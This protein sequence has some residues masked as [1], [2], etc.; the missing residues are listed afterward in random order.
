MDCAVLYVNG[1]TV[2]NLAK[3]STTGAG[4]ITVTDEM[5]T[6]VTGNAG[7]LIDSD[8]VTAASAIDGVMVG[9]ACWAYKIGALIY[10]KGASTYAKSP[11][12]ALAAFAS[13]VYDANLKFAY[14][15][16]KIYKYTT[17]DYA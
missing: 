15:E 5:P 11:K 7:D 12:S 8:V 4:S 16:G 17:S 13:A 2:Y 6:I 3:V 10:V 1:G 9:N 14:A